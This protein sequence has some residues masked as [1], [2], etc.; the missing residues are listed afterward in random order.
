[1]CIIDFFTSG[2]AEIL[3]CSV[4][5]F[6]LQDQL[7][8]IEV[9]VL[10]VLKDARRIDSFLLFRPVPGMFVESVVIAK[11]FL[12]L[13]VGVVVEILPPVLCLPFVFMAG[14]MSHCRQGSR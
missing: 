4:W 11:Q 12:D 7:P 6:C 5:S 9:V 1:M 14:A 13:V 10:V 3:S 8:G 2:E